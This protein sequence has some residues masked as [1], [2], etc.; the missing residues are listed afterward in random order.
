[1]SVTQLQLYNIAL[2]ALGERSLAS[3]TEDREPRRLLDEVWSEGYGFAR[4]VLEQGYWSHAMRAVQLDSDASLTPAFGFQYGFSRPTDLV[5]LDQISA[6]ENFTQPLMRYEI[7]TQYIYAD[8]DPMY[9]RYVSDSASYGA[10][11]SQWP[12]SFSRF[13]AHWMALQIAPR[14]LAGDAI[15]VLE[16]RTKMLLGEARSK[17]AQEQP[18]RFPPI[19]RWLSSRSRGSRL[20]R[21]KRNRLIG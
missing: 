9:L 15:L 19:G 12:E 4:A 3:L 16:K 20:D 13:S 10:D 18:P 21:G 2:R 8:V 5:K 6:D 14:I 17:E 1:M 11:L 7:E